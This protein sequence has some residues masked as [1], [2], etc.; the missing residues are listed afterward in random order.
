MPDE[1]HSRVASGRVAVIEAKPEP[2]NIDIS[3]TVVI[4]VDMQNDF[5]SKGGMFDLAGIDISMVPS[6]VGSTKKVLAAARDAGIKIVYIK[7]GYRPDLSDAGTP[8]SPNRL[9]H[10]PLRI[11]EAV[12]A[13]DGSESRILVRDTWNTDILSDLAPHA[14]DITIYK[15]RFSGFYQT[16][17][18]GI[19][20]R[21][22]AKYL[23]VTGL[24]TS[25]CVESTI[26]DAMFR[27]YSCVLLADCTGEPIGHDL[28]TSNHDASLLVIQTLFGWVSGA[29]AFLRALEARTGAAAGGQH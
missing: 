17:L 27:D 7:M 21:L 5:A 26:R 28:P 12:R 8:D 29:D 20:K 16:D 14:D 2:I 1:P 9:K 24:S 25:V 11:G 10:L 13:P 19:L 22:G 15:T 3:K 4:V 6:A 18:D 23:I